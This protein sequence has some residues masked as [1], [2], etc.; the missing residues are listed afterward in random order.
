MKKEPLKR[1]YAHLPLAFWLTLLPLVV[2][3]GTTS[4]LNE[5]NEENPRGY[6]VAYLFCSM[7]CWTAAALFSLTFTVV[8]PPNLSTKTRAPPPWTPPWLMLLAWVPVFVL[9]RLWSSSAGT[10]M[11]VQARARV[12]AMMENFI[13]A[14]VFELGFVWVFLQ[15]GLAC[16][17][18]LEG[19]FGETF[20]KTK[21]G[22]L[23]G[24]I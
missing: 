13:L 19:W 17:M 14:G 3:T 22:V 15:G 2:E 24:L 23:G 12:A 4:A 10:A 18:W 20:W 1:Q 7:I 8:S 21:G 6:P 9:W 16:A 11:A 5:G